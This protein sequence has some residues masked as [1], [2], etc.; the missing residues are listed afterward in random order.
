[1]SE[2]RA[3]RLTHPD[4]N[5]GLP[6]FLSPTAGVSSGFMMTQVTAAALVSECKGLAHP[7]SVDSIPTGASKED[8]VPMAMGAATKLRRV[9]GN[10]EH[11][12]AIELLCAMQG[13]ESRRPL[14]SGAGVEAAYATVRSLVP[15]LAED[16]VLGPDIERLARA[17][18]EGRFDAA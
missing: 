1:M 10:V 2:R 9:V 18:A 15:A 16:R 6:P 13:L 5:E 8:V 3:D 4:L 14:R 11:V 17:I 12:L 7:A